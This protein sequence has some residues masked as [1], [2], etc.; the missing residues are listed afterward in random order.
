RW[1]AQG[2]GPSGVWLTPC[3]PDLP[4]RPVYLCGPVEMMAATRQLLVQLGVPE[5][6]IQVEAFVSPGAPRLSQDEPAAPRP[7]DGGPKSVFP[8]STSRLTNGTATNLDIMAP[9]ATFARSGRRAT[10]AAESTLLEASE[11]VGVNLPFECRSG[12]CGQC[13]VRL[14]EGNVVMDSEDAISRSE[15]DAGWV[16]A[17]QARPLT[18]VTVDG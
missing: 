13:K 17:C 12:I 18:D 14:L 4:Q 10:V 15:K 7:D 5:S 2:G 8:H 11:A 6:K 3:V 16:L 1:P 9:T